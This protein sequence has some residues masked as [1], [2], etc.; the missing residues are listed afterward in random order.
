MSR[1]L[2]VAGASGALGAAVA[3]RAASRGWSVRAMVRDPA[4]LPADLVPLLA[5]VATADARDR[6]AVD[7]AVAGADAVFSCIG[8]SVMPVLGRGW[9]GYG[10]VDWPCNRTLVDAAHGAGVRRFVYVSVFHHPDMRRLAYIDAH[11]RVV[12]HLRGVGLG[13]AVVRP[14]GFHSA[15]SELV[16]MARKG[17]LPEIGG[18]GSRTNPIADDDLADV[19]AGAL[20]HADPA[21]AIDCGGP[22][23]LTRREMAE[24]AFAALGRPAR[25]RSLPA[26][27]LRF[28][29]WLGRPYHPRITQFLRF[30]VEI[31]TRD[32]IAPAHGHRRL[33]AAFAERAR[34]A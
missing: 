1:T 20:D 21:L 16:D 2:L 30:L 15:I 33:S 11:E 29:T 6:A 12:D 14:T 4:R 19:C 10:A 18:G 31:S 5:G 23:I 26:A 34:A 17:K 3:R 25:I 8:A 13:F 24:A 28:A 7:R 32:L 27:P 22:E 9:R